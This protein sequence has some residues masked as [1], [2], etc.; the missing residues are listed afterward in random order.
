MIGSDGWT[1]T[2][3][4]VDCSSVSAGSGSVGGVAVTDT[5]ALFITTWKTDNTGISSGSAITLPIV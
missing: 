3:G 4:G 5:G 1:I 2:D